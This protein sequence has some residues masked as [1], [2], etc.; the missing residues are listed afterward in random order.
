MLYGQTTGYQCTPIPPAPLET[1]WRALRWWR[2]TNIA[3]LRTALTSPEL[4]RHAV[5]FNTA[6]ATPQIVIAPLDTCLRYAGMFVGLMSDRGR[7][8]IGSYVGNVVYSIVAMGML[9]MVRPRMWRMRQ[10]GAYGLQS[11]RLPS[12]AAAH[13]DMPWAPIGTVQQGRCRPGRMRGVA[14]VT[15]P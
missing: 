4:C 11:V 9:A 5:I 6:F 10:V 3:L 8:S 7:G 15:C 13:A 14:N 2:A 1:D 12:W